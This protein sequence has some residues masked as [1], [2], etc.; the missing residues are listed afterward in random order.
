MENAWTIKPRV[1]LGDINFGMT[2]SEASSLNTTY[3]DLGPAVTA[4]HRVDATEDTIAKFGEFFSEEDIAALRQ[5][6]ASQSD[7]QVQTFSNDGP[8]LTFSK[9]HLAE[10]TIPP[11]KKAANFQD[12]IVYSIDS[13]S[14][15]VLL[16]RANGAPGRYGS[17]GAA[18]DNIAVYLDSFSFVQN[19]SVQ[20]MPSTDKRFRERTIG[21]R[22]VP[23][24]HDEMLPDF[25]AHS[26]L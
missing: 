6:A 10:I 9:N 2:P 7:S 19:G 22:E 4:Q 15:L 8:V 12:K 1:G 23:Y 3:G 21:L 25:I 24:S 20:P 13:Q 5:A 14:V 11:G 18:F 17:T 16:E 26:F